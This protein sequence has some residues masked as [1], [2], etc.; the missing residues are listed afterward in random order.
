M[1]IFGDAESPHIL[2]LTLVKNHESWGRGR[3][4]IHHLLMLISYY[5][6]D[7]HKH[8]PPIT[9]GLMVS[10]K[11]EYTEIIRQLSH[12]YLSDTKPPGS[13]VDCVVKNW[14]LSKLNIQKIFV[15]YQPKED[16]FAHNDR[17]IRH[18]ISVQKQRRRN[19]A[20]LRNQLIAYSFRNLGKSPAYELVEQVE[21][22]FGGKVLYDVLNSPLPSHF[23]WTDAD[24]LH[25]PGW[26]DIEYMLKKKDADIVTIR[27][28]RNDFGPDY[29]MNSWVGP[30][31][32]PTESQLEQMRLGN[33]TYTPYPTT[34]TKFLL[35]GITPDSSLTNKS[36]Q[37]IREIRRKNWMKLD[38]VGGTFLLVKSQV[39]IDGA[40]F[41]PYN[42]VGTEWELTEGWDG[43]ETEGLC[44]VAKTLGYQCWGLPDL[45]SE[46]DNS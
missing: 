43:I 34:S 37:Q 42:V 11:S 24:I 41:P 23:L 38:S 19:I 6:D 10:D 35:H 39:F 25:I 27:C 33:D 15:V 46:H 2:A 30:R 29:D 44:Y 13:P 20:K 21:R 8:T 22:V 17:W 1:Q 28:T 16:Q 12:I 36:P 5:D 7:S 18:L 45:T 9:I 4:I 3:S 26:D 32:K 14:I 40:I 31:T